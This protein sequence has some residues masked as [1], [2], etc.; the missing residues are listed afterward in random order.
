MIDD[1]VARRPDLHHAVYIMRDIR[2]IAVSLY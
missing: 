2:D 1:A